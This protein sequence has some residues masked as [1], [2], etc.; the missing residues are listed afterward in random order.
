MSVAAS[1]AEPGL[2]HRRTGPYRPRTNKGKADRFMQ[3][4]VRDRALVPALISR[5][6]GRSVV[7]SRIS[8]DRGDPKQ[9][10]ETSHVGFDLIDGGAAVR[11]RSA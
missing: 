3:G 5:D 1:C 11:D 7:N 4:V 9:S 10:V 6:P 2:K 8:L